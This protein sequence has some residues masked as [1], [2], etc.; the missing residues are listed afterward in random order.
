MAKRSIWMLTQFCDAKICQ[1][2]LSQFPKLCAQEIEP[3]FEK[4]IIWAGKEIMI[5]DQSIY[6]FT[7]NHLPQFNQPSSCNSMYSDI[8]H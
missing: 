2:E 7:K 4:L 5:L 1:S 6:I 8:H 3:I